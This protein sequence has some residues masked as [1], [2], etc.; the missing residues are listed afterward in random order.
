MTEHHLRLKSY[1][2][3]FLQRIQYVNQPMI[4]PYSQIDSRLQFFR[5]GELVHN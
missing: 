2:V 4:L 3:L 5:R 1:P